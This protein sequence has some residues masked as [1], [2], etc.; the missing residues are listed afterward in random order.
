[1]TQSSNG[2][3]PKPPNLFEIE[4]SYANVCINKEL[5]MKFEDIERD[6]WIR[7]KDKY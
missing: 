5:F 2:A 1:M 4:I 3:H 7:Y 6:M